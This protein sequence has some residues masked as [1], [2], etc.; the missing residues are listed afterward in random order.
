MLIEKA[1]AA[2]AGKDY[3][4]I[5]GGGADSVFRALTGRKAEQASISGDDA[6]AAETWANITTWL[7]QGRPVVADCPYGEGQRHAF[8][9]LSLTGKDWKSGTVVKKNPHHRAPDPPTPFKAFVKQFDT[10]HVGYLP[11]AAS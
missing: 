3:A 5:E 6:K 8:S 1:Y 9:V 11:G 2:W 10:V 7:K 4:G